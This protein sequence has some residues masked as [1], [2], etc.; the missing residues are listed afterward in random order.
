M[1]RS[2]ILGASTMLNILIQHLPLQSLFWT[3]IWRAFRASDPS[4]AQTGSDTGAIFKRLREGLCWCQAQSTLA[5][6]RETT[7]R[8]AVSRSRFSRRDELLLSLTVSGIQAG[9]GIGICRKENQAIDWGGGRK[10]G[11][12]WGDEVGREHG[13]VWPSEGE[14]QPYV[15]ANSGE[16]V[17]GFQP[18]EW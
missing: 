1:M 5:L 17:E 10:L 18:R 7:G 13:G 6:T 11:G 12:F 16:R 8:C 15:E 2:S 4:K 9:R 14:D 3:K